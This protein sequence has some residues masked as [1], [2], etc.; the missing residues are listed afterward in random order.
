MTPLTTRQQIFVTLG[1]ALL[2]LTTRGEHLAAVGFLPD[3]SWAIFFL[4]GAYL[5][6]SWAF[7]GFN[8]LALALDLAAVGWGGVSA[9]CLSPAYVLLLPAHA[10]LWAG[11]RWY[12]ARHR[13]AWSTLFPLGASLLVA[14]VAA[15]L[16]AS[17][18]FYLVSGRFADT[19]VAGLGERLLTYFPSSLEALAFYVGLAA[20]MHVGVAL[21]AGWARRG[22]ALGH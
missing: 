1:L 6:S 17:G 19:S 11:G 12:A 4:A 9:F 20:V 10:A 3:A 15:E 7:W 8:A 5:R 16:L 14:V 22:G 21:T 13:S 18:G 2:M